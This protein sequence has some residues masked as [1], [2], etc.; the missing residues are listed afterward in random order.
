MHQNIGRSF[1]VYQIVYWSVIVLDQDRVYCITVLWT[2]YG[3]LLRFFFV[4]FGLHDKQWVTNCN[5]IE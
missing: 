3:R 1:G 5:V 2:C 4:Y